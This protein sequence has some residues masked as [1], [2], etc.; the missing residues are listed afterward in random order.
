ML[1]KHQIKHRSKP[2][3]DVELLPD[4]LRELNEQDQ[5]S[6]SGGQIQRLQEEFAAELAALGAMALP[7]FL[8]RPKIPR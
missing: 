3:L 2:V 1:G 8:N 5:E 7:S 4:I 6:I